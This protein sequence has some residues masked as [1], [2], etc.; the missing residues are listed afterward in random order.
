MA[1]QRQLHED[2]VHRV[3]RVQLGDEREQVVLA[4]LGG[5]LVVVGLDPR[6]GAASCFLPM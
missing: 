2:P 3:V 1:G 6:L 5:Q 4:G